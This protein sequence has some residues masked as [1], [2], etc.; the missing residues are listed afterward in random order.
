MAGRPQPQE[1]HGGPRWGGA[2]REQRGPEALLLLRH[3]EINSGRL[4]L[5]RKRRTS[6][7]THRTMQ[8]RAAVRREGARCPIFFQGRWRADSPLRHPPQDLSAASE[9]VVSQRELM[10]GAQGSEPFLS[11][12]GQNPQGGA[13]FEEFDIELN[14]GMVG[15]FSAALEAQPPAGQ[16]PQEN[17]GKPGT[18]GPATPG[19]GHQQFVQQH[20]QDEM[21][22]A[23][24]RRELQGLGK[25][26]TP[27]TP[28]TDSVQGRR[29]ET[30]S[31]TSSVQLR[32]TQTPTAS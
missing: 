21:E 28:Q 7:S 26:G 1:L 29:K 30:S 15:L 16:Q 3:K 4:S 32:R 14:Q 25:D 31:G 8:Q 23:S 13:R 17:W 6:S 20:L 24:R 12:Q 9:V 27:Q 2:N 18:P 10:M 11:A 22:E 19:Q 5:Q